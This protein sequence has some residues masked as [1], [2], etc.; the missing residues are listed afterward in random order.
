MKS[1]ETSTSDFR[2]WHVYALLSMAAAAAAVWVARNTHPLALLLLSGIVLATG[3]AALWIHHALTAFFSNPRDTEPLGVRAREVLE[4]EKT[5][6]LRSIKELEFDRAMGKVGDADFAEMS[7]RLRAR[8][9]SLMQDLERSDVRV[10]AA[11]GRLNVRLECPAC[12]TTNEPDAKFCKHC[13][14]RLGP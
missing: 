5:L 8:A 2:V 6:T 4:R 14:E 13:G 10:P 7:S 12:R 1:S 3:W 9:L 11:P